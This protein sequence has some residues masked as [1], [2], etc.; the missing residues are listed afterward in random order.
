MAGWPHREND[1][2]GMEIATSQPVPQ[3]AWF[4]IDAF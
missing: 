4:G 2:A 3:P 1:Q